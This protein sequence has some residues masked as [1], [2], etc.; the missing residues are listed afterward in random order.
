MRAKGDAA[1]VNPRLK[2]H[3]IRVVM[4]DPESL[5]RAVV[6]PL[7]EDTSD[8]EVSCPTA[9]ALSNSFGTETPTCC[10]SISKCH[11]ETAWKFSKGCKPRVCP[12]GRLC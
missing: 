3:P 10:C 5:F 2:T 8:I 9:G 1:A 11:I 12:F 6:L 4:A 7:F